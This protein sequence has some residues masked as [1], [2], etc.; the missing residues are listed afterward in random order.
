[1]SRFN[2]QIWFWQEI[3]SPHMGHLAA[4]LANLG[5]DVIFVANQIL[6][7]ERLKQG[8]ERAELGKAKLK[9]AKSKKTYEQLAQKA[10]INSIH[11]FQGLRGNGLI[12]NAQRILRKR[13]LK[14]WAM[15][16]KID[17]RG[18]IGKLRRVL[19][20]V[21]FLYWRKHLD[22]VLAFGDG[23]RDWIIKRGMKK[24]KVFSFAY[25][26]KETKMINIPKN[27]KKKK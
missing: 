12:I 15:L 13:N 26:L 27:S 16:E 25:F 2:N 5:H 3:L 21:I 23:T 19:Y 9:L 22:G 20:R 4:E 11:F 14:H 8:W 17:D 6:S 24:N 7:K 1:M 10:P 18:L